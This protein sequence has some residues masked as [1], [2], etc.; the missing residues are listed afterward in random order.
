MIAV[1]KS[2]AY[3]ER[4]ARPEVGPQGRYTVRGHNIGL[5]DIDATVWFRDHLNE[6]SCGLEG[7][8][9]HLHLFDEPS[10][11]MILAATA[12]LFNLPFDVV[13]RGVL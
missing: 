11:H 7:V 3:R 5:G 9:L 1:Q 6:Y 4:P 12:A 13:M 2:G 8:L 10:R